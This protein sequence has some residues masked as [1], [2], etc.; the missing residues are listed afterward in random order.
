MA[1]LIFRLHDVPDDEAC[2]IRE[3]LSRHELDYYETQTGRWR[4]GLAAIWLKDN[5]RFAEAR[6]YIDAYQAERY[7]RLQQEP[8]IKSLYQQTREHP[9]RFLAAL[10]L[11]GI[12]LAISVLPFL[13]F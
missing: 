3:L 5:Q 7:Q 1:K 4:V 10:F 8:P 6:A 2:D 13:H 9:I 11:L 12:V